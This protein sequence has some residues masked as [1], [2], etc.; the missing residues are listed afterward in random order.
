MATSSFFGERQIVEDISDEVE[1]LLCSFET[2]GIRE[3]AFK[4]CPG[5]NLARVPL[6]V[7]RQ[8]EQNGGTRQPIQ[9]RIHTRCIPP[10]K[11]GFQI[12]SHF[13]LI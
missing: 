3:G 5:F 13:S 9:C 12:Q 8:E 6:E 4:L 11:L 1:D 10:R 2:E 7:V